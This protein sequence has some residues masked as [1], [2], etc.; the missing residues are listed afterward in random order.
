MLSDGELKDKTIDEL[1]LL[2]KLQPAYK[3]KFFGLFKKRSRSYESYKKRI[4][5][6]ICMKKRV[7]YDPEYSV[8]RVPKRILKMY[9]PVILER[10][11]L[12]EQKGFEYELSSLT[13]SGVRKLPMRLINEIEKLDRRKRYIISENFKLVPNTI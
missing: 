1:L 11:N 13:P 4:W 7:I 10:V 6:H 8:D 9:D 2:Y 12:L 5:A 3:K